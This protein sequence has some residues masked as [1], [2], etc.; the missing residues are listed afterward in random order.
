[1]ISLYQ[2]EKTIFAETLVVQIQSEPR[3]DLKPGCEE[4]DM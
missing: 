4:E 3:K 2:Q 1:M